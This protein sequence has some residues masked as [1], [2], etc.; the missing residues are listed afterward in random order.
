MSS[1]SLYQVTTWSSCHVRVDADTANMVGFIQDWLTIMH[2][3]TTPVLCFP[4]HRQVSHEGSHLSFPVWLRSRT[5]KLKE[6]Y[7][8]ETLYMMFWLQAGSREE[9][10]LRCNQYNACHWIA[11]TYSYLYGLWL[12]ESQL[13]LK[14]HRNAEDCLRFSDLGIMDWN[15]QF[16]VLRFMCVFVCLY[17]WVWVCAFVCV[18]YV[19]PCPQRPER[20]HIA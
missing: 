3:R 16:Y 5:V 18:H 11:L 8:I 15:R 17:V 14:E 2:L 13:W 4:Y 10:L 1:R 19:L 6:Q 7:D 12:A 9:R 20:C